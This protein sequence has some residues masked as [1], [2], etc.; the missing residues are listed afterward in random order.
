MTSLPTWNE[1]AIPVLQYL[2]DG[3]TLSGRE[4]VAGVVEATGLTAEQLAETLPSTGERK[5]DNRIGW[6]M[7]Y[8]TRV[9]A[10]AR[11]K[12]GHYMITARGHQALKDFPEGLTDSDFRELALPGDEWWLKKRT[13]GDKHTATAVAEDNG[14]EGLDP[15]EQVEQGIARIHADVA[16]DLLSRLQDHEPTFFEHAVVTLLVAMGY[17]GADGRATVTQASGD[18]G[19]DGVIDRDALGLD[20]VYIQAKRYGSENPVGR[21]DIQR[22][23]GA[24]SGKASTGVFIT[25]GR[26]S[27]GA[28]EYAGQAHTRVILIDGGRL[29]ELMI[30]YGVGV[31]AKQALQIVEVDEDFFE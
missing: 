4:I 25:T 10:L 29:T 31:Q 26:F 19:I 7:S 17:G 2:Q 1:F 3:S 24:L 6:A 12:R 28:I 18:G 13:E 16:A 8:L 11:P 30:R 5:A 22:F 14:S 9:Q 27:P 15:R 20:R 23:V 21:P